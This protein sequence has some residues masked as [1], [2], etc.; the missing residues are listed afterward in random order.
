MAVNSKNYAETS[1]MN[2]IQGIQIVVVFLSCL[3]S[4]KKNN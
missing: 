1:N 2:L 3:K 4:V